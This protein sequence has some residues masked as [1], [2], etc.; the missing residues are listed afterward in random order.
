MRNTS[1]FCVQAIALKMRL[2][3]LYCIKDSFFGDGG[4]GGR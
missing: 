3:I 2:L 4:G 1:I